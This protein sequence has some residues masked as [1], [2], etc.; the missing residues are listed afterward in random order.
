LWFEV[1]SVIFKLK[2]SAEAYKTLKKAI[3]SGYL[4]PGER[5]IEKDLAEKMGISRIPVRE[6]IKKLESERL[7]TVTANKGAT[8]VKM[9]PIEIEETYFIVGCLEGLAAKLAIGNLDF[10]AFEKFTTLNSGM[11][12]D[13]TREDYRGWHKKNIEFHRV[14]IN[15]CRKPILAN[16]ILENREGLSRYWL[17]ACLKPGLL[18][19]CMAHHKEI[20]EAFKAKNPELARKLVEFHY[21]SIGTVVKEY[22]EKLQG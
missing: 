10:K 5:L 22:F 14:Y 17:Y 20:M 16:L 9:S 7:I 2:S 19:T 1:A 6:A 15:G 21:M 12:E 11:F 3:V 4:V 18:E 8:V 13:I